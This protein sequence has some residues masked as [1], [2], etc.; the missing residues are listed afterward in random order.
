MHIERGMAVQILQANNIDAPKRTSGEE[1]GE[2]D[3]RS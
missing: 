2:E 1:E 3:E